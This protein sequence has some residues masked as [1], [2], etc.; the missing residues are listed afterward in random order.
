MFDRLQTYDSF[1][2]GV[3]VNAGVNTVGVHGSSM[4]AL[5]QFNV[6]TE[7]NPPGAF[8]R[9]GAAHSPRLLYGNR[10]RSSMPCVATSLASVRAFW[11]CIVRSELPRLNAIAV[12]MTAD[13]PMAITISMRVNPA[14]DAPSDAR[15]RTF[16]QARRRLIRRGIS[17]SAERLERTAGRVRSRPGTGR[18]RRRA[19]GRRWLGRAVGRDRSRR[20]CRC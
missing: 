8:G 10:W 1:G 17:G 2:T 15:R 6:I 11:S 4:D 12:M 13:R 14:S 19:G 9:G 18:R 7:L 5:V 3:A 16:D 20:C